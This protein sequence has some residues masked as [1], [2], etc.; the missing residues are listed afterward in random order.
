MI[1]CFMAGCIGAWHLPYGIRAFRQR[2]IAVGA[3]GSYVELTGRPAR[4][5][6]LLNIVVA[7]LSTLLGFGFVAFELLS[8]TLG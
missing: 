6:A 2:R 8:K 7:A 5:Q 1:L 3:G 4:K